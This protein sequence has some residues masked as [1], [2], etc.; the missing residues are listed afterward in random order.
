MALLH[1]ELGRLDEG[2]RW[3]DL[4]IEPRDP[5]LVHLGVAPQWDSLRGDPRFGERLARMGLTASG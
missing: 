1:G 3:L 2:F 4:A 5:C